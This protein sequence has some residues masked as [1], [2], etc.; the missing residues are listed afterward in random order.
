V[1]SAATVNIPIPN[2][3]SG[4]VFYGAGSTTAAPLHE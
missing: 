1:Q 2:A 4:L 3:P